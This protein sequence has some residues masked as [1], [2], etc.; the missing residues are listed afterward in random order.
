MSAKSLSLDES[1]DTMPTEPAVRWWKL[2]PHL[3]CHKPS[4]KPGSRSA[5]FREVWSKNTPSLS[6][7]YT[8]SH[9][10]LRWPP[11]VRKTQQTGPDGGC[12]TWTVK[13]RLNTCSLSG[14]RHR[15]CVWKLYTKRSREVCAQQR[16]KMYTW[17]KGVWQKKRTFIRWLYLRLY[18][19]ILATRADLYICFCVVRN[20]VHRV[21][22][23]GTNRLSRPAAFA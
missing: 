8:S 20:C 9:W 6:S 23:P 3:Q 10:K 17:R 7:I 14:L 1:G 16:K 19:M 18:S 5:A 15:V 4:I 11:D 12:L 21:E 13:H 2:Y 22:L